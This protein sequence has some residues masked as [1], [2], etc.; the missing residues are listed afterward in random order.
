MSEQQVA[1]A[2]EPVIVARERALGHITLN[3]PKSINALTLEMVR[4]IDAALDRFEHDDA[5]KVVLLDGAGERGFCAGGD[6]IVLYDAARTGELT[7][8]QDFWREEYE[9]NARIANYRKPL[10]AIMDGIVMGGGVGLAGH[11]RHRVATERLG[12]A[13]PEVGI[14]FAPDV[15]G[16]YLLS[17]APGQLGT[18]LGLLG[19]RIGAGDALLC[20]LA[21]T[22]V[23]S[24][25][26][27]A[28]AERLQAGDVAGALA[29]VQAPADLPDGK[30]AGARGWIDTAFAADSA[31]EILARLYARPEPAAQE[32]AETI[33]QKS[34]TSVAVTLRALRSARQLPS[35][36]AC[37][38][39]EYR[40]S[41][42]FLAT[43]DFVEGIRAAVVDKDRRPRWNPATL[44]QLPEHEI[45]RFFN[46][47]QDVKELELAA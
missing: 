22:V 33:T 11:A 14:G 40:T 21:D 16:T 36:E 12:I 18:Y 7:A 31:G 17:R 3:R 46:P 15:G 8:A 10:V 26:L 1:T 34:P 6:I 45:E 27:A 4:M 25:A 37:L 32:A 9:L 19:S 30:L 20:G 28:L 23:Y 29:A 13:M 39:Q 42:A 38:A 47:L 43:P 24:S 35:L 41:L 2:P 44:E 5:V